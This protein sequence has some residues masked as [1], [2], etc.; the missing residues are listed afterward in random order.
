[1]NEAFVRSFSFFLPCEFSSVSISNFF[2]HSLGHDSFLM[3]AAV[4]QKQ[5]GLCEKFFYSWWLWLTEWWE[6]ESKLLKGFGVENLWSNVKRKMR[7]ARPKN[8]DELKAA[9]KSTL[10]VI[11]PQQCH[12]LM[13]FMSHHTDTVIHAK[14]RPNQVPAFSKSVAKWCRNGRSFMG[15]PL[16]L[17]MY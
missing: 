1:M 11:T 15:L 4:E 5:G 2:V 14:M 3:Q 6:K 17:V 10:V 8:S 12:R 16:Q 7:D 9:I 13:A